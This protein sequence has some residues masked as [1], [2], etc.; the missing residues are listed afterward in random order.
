MN[1]IPTTTLRKIRAA[2]PCKDGYKYLL[3]Q[4]P[5]GWDEDD[6]ISLPALLLLTRHTEDVVWVCVLGLFGPA[7]R[8]ADA[9]IVVFIADAKDYW[10]LLAAEL[11]KVE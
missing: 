1:H 8:I 9:N 10:R 3:S 2:K 5:P 7:V 6:E 4:L 11:A